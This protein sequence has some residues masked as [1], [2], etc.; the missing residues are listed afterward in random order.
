YGLAVFTTPDE[1]RIIGVDSA[2]NSQ[3]LYTSA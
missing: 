2:G 3:T 1:D